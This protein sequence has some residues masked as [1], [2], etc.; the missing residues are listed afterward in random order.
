M[1]CLKKF[2]EFFDGID[3]KWGGVGSGLI[4]L[5]VM[6]NSLICKT[7]LFGTSLGD[8]G[9]FGDLSCSKSLKDGLISSPEFIKFNCFV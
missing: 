3:V 7:C 6:G 1:F 8:F 9:D 2:G 5:P 4:G